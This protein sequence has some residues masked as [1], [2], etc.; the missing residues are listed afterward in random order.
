MI[1]WNIP[2]TCLLYLS[3]LRPLLVSAERDHRHRSV[4]SLTLGPGGG[5]SYNEQCCWTVLTEDG[6][7]DAQFHCEVKIV[8]DCEKAGT[9][10]LQQCVKGGVDE[11]RRDTCNERPERWLNVAVPSDVPELRKG[12]C[13]IRAMKIFLQLRVKDLF[14]MTQFKE[15]EENEPAFNLTT[16]LP[17]ISDILTVD[18]SRGSRRD[19]QGLKDSQRG[20]RAYRDTH[21]SFSMLSFGDLMT[22]DLFTSN[23]ERAKK[24]EMTIS[25]VCDLSLISI[26]HMITRRAVGHALANDCEISPYTPNTILSDALVEGCW[27]NC[28]REVDRT[29]SQHP[30]FQQLQR[31]EENRL[32]CKGMDTSILA[33]LSYDLVLAKTSSEGCSKIPHDTFTAIIEFIF[34]RKCLLWS[35]PSVLWR[36]TDREAQKDVKYPAHEV[37]V[38]AQK[39]PKSFTFARRNGT[40]CPEGHTCNNRKEER[41]KYSTASQLRQMLAFEDGKITFV[42]GTAKQ[43]LGTLTVGTLQHVASSVIPGPVVPALFLGAVAIHAGVQHEWV[44]LGAIMAGAAAAVTLTALHSPLVITAGAVW[45]LQAS[46]KEYGLPYKEEHTGC[47]PAEAVVDETDEVGIGNCLVDVSSIWERNGA[48]INPAAFMPP[49]GVKVQREE[50]QLVSVGAAPPHPVPQCTLSGCSMEDLLQQK[51]GFF[52]KMSVHKDLGEKYLGKELMNC[53]PLQWREMTQHQQEQ[54][55]VAIHNSSTGIRPFRGKNDKNI[56]WTQ[57]LFTRLLHCSRSND[58]CGWRAPPKLR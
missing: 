35:P 23:Q 46:I 8:A 16:S 57:P 58:G 5:P 19:R 42:E 27:S 53:Q 31:V 30:F 41:T 44:K 3:N 6:E 25:S 13:M 15:N 28:I 37:C 33:N 34:Q 48:L 1:L 21:T 45:L 40:M 14:A 56:Y 55:A 11:N 39:E 18:R 50:N 29:V 17:S 43:T 54:F 22:N 51:V 4:S 52:E 38:Q 20:R 10:K 47:W 7:L 24:Y 2:I 12:A 26:W 9:Y 49:P 36:P 32:P